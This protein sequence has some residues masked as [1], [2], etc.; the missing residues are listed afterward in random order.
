[1]IFIWMFS[2]GFQKPK[3]KTPFS[4]I[5]VQDKKNMTNNF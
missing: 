5:F 2:L 4:E 3:Y 1:M